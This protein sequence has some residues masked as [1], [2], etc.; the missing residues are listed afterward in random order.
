LLEVV[1]FMETYSSAQ[2]WRSWI[3]QLPMNADVVS[4]LLTILRKAVV[5]K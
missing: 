4:L 2:L 3:T 5:Q 1:P